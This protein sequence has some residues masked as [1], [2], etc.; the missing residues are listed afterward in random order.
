MKDI[1]VLTVCGETLPEAFESALV[2]LYR[3][4]ASITTEYDK[5]EDPPSKDSTMNITIYYPEKE[6]RIHK[7]F[8]GGIEDLRE[9]VMELEGVKDHWV[10]DMNVSEDTR[11][12]Y[13]Y[14]GRLARWG[15]W[16]DKQKGVSYYNRFPNGIA[17][18]DQ[19]Q[20]VINKLT[21]SPHTRRAQMITWMPN[22]DNE[23]FDPPCLQSLWYRITEDSGNFYLN[24]N[25]RF[26]SNDAWGASFMNMFGFIY[27]NRN[28]IMRGL[29]RRGMKNLK[30]S[31]L[32]WHADSY[33]IYGKDIKTFKER[34]YDRLTSDYVG[35]TYCLS[36]PNI[37]SIWDESKANIVEKIEKYDKTHKK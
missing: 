8:P 17:D 2:S 12:E 21:E 31:R 18:V 23:C 15:I 3:Y 19:I 22:I 24:C 30:M 34:F 26:R 1:P 29:E 11:W 14:H 35:R 9:Y 5:K 32:N 10:K 20:H 36:D 7:A 4:G 25:V 33:H 37:Q 13:T 27:F 6:P 16:M 28:V